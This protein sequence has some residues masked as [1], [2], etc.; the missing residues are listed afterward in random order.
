MNRINN[1]LEHLKSYRVDGI[2][3]S[4]VPN[5]TYL[6]DFTGDSSVLIVS[7]DRC[8]LLTDGRYTEQAG[9]ECPGEIE[10]FKWLNNKRFGVETYQYIVK[11]LKIKRLGFEG[12]VMSFSSYES[13]R[14]GLSGIELINM[15]GCVEKIR[16]VKDAMEIGFLKTACEISV[17]ALEKTL[18]LVKE[19]V[20]EKEIAARLDYYLRDQ[21]ADAI[22]FDTIVLTGPR[23]S[24]LHG[25]PGKH[26]IRKGDY[27]L[28]DFGALYKGYHADISRTFVIGKPDEQQKELYNIIQKAQMAGVMS[29][30]PGMSGR[31]PDTVVRKHIPENYIS[32]YYPGL[33]HG[34]GLQ[35]HETPF[36]GQSSE[37]LLE[38]NMVLTV[39]PGIYI[40]GWG[41]L[42]IEDTVWIKDDGAAILTDFPRDMMIL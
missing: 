1:L 11:E 6:S 10:V 32:Y 39:E 25:K 14:K 18:P 22:S 35:I 7:P 41:G 42:R 36:L 27:V 8:I 26:K 29:L 3:I 40:P 34:V 5:V 12:H 28:F 33:G 20:T 37:A 31:D 17:K 16:Q 2:L 24:L 13:L 30:I 15:E 38:N 21:G 19:G 23:T 9:N 4:S